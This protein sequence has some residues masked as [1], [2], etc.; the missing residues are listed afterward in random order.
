MSHLSRDRPTLSASDAAVQAA[1]EVF[2]LAFP[3]AHETTSDHRLRLVVALMLEC[4][5]RRGEGSAE[6]IEFITHLEHQKD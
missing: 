3:D 6:L 4:G 2:R 1:S 5:L